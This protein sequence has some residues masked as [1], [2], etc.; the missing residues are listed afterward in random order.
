MRRSPRELDPNA[1]PQDGGGV[2]QWGFAERAD[3][4]AAEAA[5]GRGAG[6]SRGSRADRSERASKERTPLIVWILAGLGAVAA[7]VSIVAALR[8][9]TAL[10]WV[11]PAGIGLFLG[12]GA[13]VIAALRGARKWPGVV[14]AV[15][16]VAG[17]AAPV[18]TATVQ[19]AELEKQA[20]ALVQDED[21][22]AAGDD[23]NESA[24]ASDLPGLVA[25][26]LPVGTGADVG[27][28]RVVVQKVE[29]NAGAAVASEDPQAPA[30]EGRYV[31]ATVEVGNRS[32]AAISPGTDLTYELI[33]GDGTQVDA[34]TC[35]A[36]LQDSPVL[37][38]DLAAGETGTYNVCFD[39]PAE[40]NDN[41][42][43]ESSAVR[44]ADALASDRSAGFWS[45][46]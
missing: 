39:V 4:D 16:C 37:A 34:L 5:G 3:D 22:E 17:I 41:A 18:T 45:A 13:W 42:V 33:A 20:Q 2:G 7:A 14:A 23:F 12:G 1:Q 43:L 25:G 36:Q 29:L 26:A 40:M 10:N 19:R 28:L 35:G 44:V 15:L 6:R 31:T 38:A 11:W 24:V 46:G 30:P 9:E 32:D 27:Q 8:P 21:D